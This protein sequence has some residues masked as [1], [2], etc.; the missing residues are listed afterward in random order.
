ML[1]LLPDNPIPEPKTLEEAQAIIVAL[2]QQV[3]E[4]SSRLE[5]LEESLAQGSGN[6]SK[7]PSQ[8]DPKQRAE[9]KK[10]APTGRHRGA[11][12][13]HTKHE[14]ALLPEEQVDRIERFYPQGR[15][16]CGGEI[17]PEPEAQQRHQVFDL[18]EIRYTVT[19]YQTYA[20]R[21]RCCQARQVA[22]LPEAVPQGQMGAGLIG[23]IALM[24]GQYHA[25]TRQIQSLLQQQWGLDFSLGAVSQ[26]QKP[27][28]GWLQPIYAQIGE[29]VRQ[30]CVAHADETTHYRGGER[31]WLWT[32]SSAQAVYFL[33]HYSRGKG[34][35]RELLQD[36]D[37]ILVSDR[38]GGYND[39]PADR[40]QLCWAHLIRNLESIAI[41]R[42]EAGAL[43][44]RLVRLARLVV[45]VE[46]R[47]QHSG[48]ASA[49]QR[50]RLQRLQ[51]RLHEALEAGTQAHEGSRTGNQCRRLLG[52]EG[53]FWTF[54]KH[55]GL[56]LTNNLAERALRPYVIWRKISFFSQSARGDQFR[57]MILSI[58]ETCKRLGGQC[59]FRSA[60]SLPA[61]TTERTRHRALAHPSTITLAAR[62]GV[63]RERLPKSLA[64]KPGGL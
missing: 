64:V 60:P 36:F 14:R 8:D 31:R 30:A 61:G 40:R 56:P 37:G 2:V 39:Y 38:H 27:V 17:V 20:G 24:A 25:T 52:E 3:R 58:T 26:A 6:S 44:Q 59:L 13:G 33:T 62:N 29:A 34:A 16:A 47:W 32:L 42:G 55:P 35:A 57:P 1:T 41:R 5:A 48:Y 19:E 45:R 43:G 10:K 54:L 51:T 49:R 22:K 28:S 50:Q 9:R 12:P 21:C 53:M 18:P 7:P 11:Q 63:G 4:M 46:H 23:W 15:C